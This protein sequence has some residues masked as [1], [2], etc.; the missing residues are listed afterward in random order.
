[1]RGEMRRERV[2]RAL[3]RGVVGDAG[4]AGG[5]ARKPGRALPVVGEQ[6]VDIGADHA[7]VGRDRALGRSVGEPRKRPRAVRPFG[8]AHMHLVAGK[9]HAVG[10]RAAHRFEAL[11]GRQTSFRRRSGRGRRLLPAD[12]R[13]RRD[14]RCCGPAS[15]SRRTGRRT[16]PPRRR[17]AAM[18]ISNPAA[19]SASR[20]AI[21]AFEPGSTIEIG[22]A[23]QR[24]A[25]PHA[26][27]IDRGLGI[28]RIEIVE[29]GDVRQD[30]HRDAQPRLRFC[31]PALL[32][33]QRILRRQQ[34]RVRKIRHEA[35]RP[36]SGQLR[37]ALHAR[38]QTAPHR[39]EIC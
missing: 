25:R 9:R 27:E 1:M 4:R 8:H 11:F 37:D 18:S 33:R 15:D 19:R 24:R 2:E 23:G 7:A 22:I 10:G 5:E 34:P 29:I 6:A 16:V 31:R 39:R 26:N 36:P 21:V 17:C 3:D 32:E 38:R 30:R 28:E 13:C 20:S 35:E 12:L 14:R